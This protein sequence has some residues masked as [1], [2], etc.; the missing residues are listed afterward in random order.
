MDKVVLS[1]IAHAIL[2]AVVED[3]LV[4]NINES[5]EKGYPVEDAVRDSLKKARLLFKETSTPASSNK[6]EAPKKTTTSKTV[7]KDVLLDEND[8]PRQCCA[9]KKS[10]SKQCVQKAKYEYNGKY[11][12]GTHNKS[13]QSDKPAKGKKPTFSS[14]QKSSSSLEDAMTDVDNDL[15][16][17]L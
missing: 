6:Q 14:S 12:C 9:I 15:N 1:N 2:S 5:I 11:Y 8:Q 3:E 7:S 16:L 10:D 4:A 17:E 13:A